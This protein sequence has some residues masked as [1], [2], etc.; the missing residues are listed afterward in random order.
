VLIAS[1]A[2][3]PSETPLQSLLLAWDFPVT[4]FTPG[5]SITPLNFGPLFFF[6]ECLGDRAHNLATIPTGN[7]RFN[8]AAANFRPGRFALV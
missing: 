7:S 4:E 3:Q 5:Y 8:L 2:L 6:V 1:F